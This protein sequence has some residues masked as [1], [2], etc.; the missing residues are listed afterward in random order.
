MEIERREF[1]GLVCDELGRLWAFGFFFFLSDGSLGFCFH[2]DLLIGWFWEGGFVGLDCA[3][4]GLL[5]AFGGFSF[6]LMGFFMLG[7]WSPFFLF[8]VFLRS[9]CAEW[10]LLWAFR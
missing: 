4:Q 3:R 2:L 1:L 10:R 6:C 8:S 5:W 9:V 7:F